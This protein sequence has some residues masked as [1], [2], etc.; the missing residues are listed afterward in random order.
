MKEKIQKIKQEIVKELEKVQ[1]LD[2]LKELEVKFLGRKGKV[3]NVLK[4]IKDLSAEEK[5][6]LGK[7][8]N[9]QK[10]EIIEIFQKNK[11]KLSGAKSGVEVD[12]TM[13]GKKIS[14]GHIH[15]ITQIQY[16]LEDLF[17]SMGF[18]VLYGPELESDFFNFEALN[19]PSHHPARD[20]QDT[21][22]VS[23]GDDKKKESDFVMRTHTSPMQVRAM[24]KYGAPF[25]GVV[26]GRVFRN[27]EVDDCH[28]HTFDQIEGL[29]VGEDI[30]LANLIT[31]LKEVMKGVFRQDLKI[32]VRPG[33]FPFVE[34]GIEVDVNCT[35]CGGVGCSSCK[36]TGWLEMVGAGMVHPKVLEYGGIDVEKYTGFAFGIGLTRLAMMKYGVEDIRMFNAG[37]LRFLKQF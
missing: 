13:P 33:Y 28:D 17:S 24:K 32:R 22:Y 19:I 9:Q 35:I 31:V 2:A 12:V 1:S 15:P 11:N 4:G 5:K 26:P 23:V 34:P 6:T 37:D 8:A 7:E 18:S 21:F 25:R 27:E 20:M 30:S 29:M 36:H 16:D 14:G 10:N 3:T